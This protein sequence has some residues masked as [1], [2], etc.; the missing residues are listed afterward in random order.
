MASLEKLRQ[1]EKL[2]NIRRG[3]TAEGKETE[4]YQI[5]V[6][7]LQHPRFNALIYDSRLLDIIESLIGP[8]IRIILIQGIYKPP[9]TG[10]EI[11]WHQDNYYFQVDKK[12]G[13]ASC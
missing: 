5:R 10:G 12:D 11:Q 4:V 1:Q 8:N 2:K 13:V 6:A 7:H 3:R 9:L